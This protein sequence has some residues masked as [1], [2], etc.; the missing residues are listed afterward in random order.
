MP[1][2]AQR[3]I[4]VYGMPLRDSDSSAR[5]CWVAFQT[6]FIHQSQPAS[7]G[8]SEVGVSTTQSKRDAQT[9]ALAMLVPMVAVLSRVGTANRKSS[10]RSQVAS[11]SP[12]LEDASHARC[13]EGSGTGSLARTT[14]LGEDAHGSELGASLL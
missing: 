3:C 9:V 14:A 5:M 7:G 11:L 12:S 8:M 1:E 4:V 10:C 6:V 13:G 2:P